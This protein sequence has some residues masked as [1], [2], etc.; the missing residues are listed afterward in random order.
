MNKIHALKPVP[1]RACP[2]CGF[3]VD[4]F[5]IE[6]AKYNFSCAKC[7]KHKLSEFIRTTLTVE[8]KKETQDE[9]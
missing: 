9:H 2:S 5:K 3:L 7:G 8:P 6:A 4:Q 1:L